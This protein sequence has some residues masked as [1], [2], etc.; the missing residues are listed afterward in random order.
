M[1]KHTKRLWMMGALVMGMGMGFSV[2]ATQSAPQPATQGSVECAY[3]YHCD[4]KC[5]GPGSGA[6]YR[7]RCGCR[8]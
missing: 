6:C 2:G 7:G 1:I 8:W 3:D 5:G 4:E